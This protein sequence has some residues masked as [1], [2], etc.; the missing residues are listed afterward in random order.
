LVGIVAVQGLISNN[1]TGECEEG[2][3]S[4]QSIFSKLSVSQKILES[5]TIKV[6]LV[7]TLVFTL[8]WIVLNQFFLYRCRS[9]ETIADEK[10]CTPSDFAVFLLNLPEGTTKEDIEAMLN[11][12]RKI[13]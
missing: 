3:C 12:T 11:H 8:L 4:Y 10:I 1:S 13:I 7:L 9:Y 6:E 2:N 5:G